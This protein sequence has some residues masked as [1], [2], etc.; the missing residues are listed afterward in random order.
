MEL[1]EHELSSLFP[2]VTAQIRSTLASLHI[3]AAQLA[4]ASDRE[5]DSALDLRAARVDQSY[6][7]LLRLVNT[8]SLAASLSGGQPLPLKNHDLVRLTGQVCEQMD[9]LVTNQGLTLR[10]S[11]PLDQ[12]LCAA[13]KESLEQILFQL[14][15]NAVKF[16]PPGGVITV[17]LRRSFG[18]VLL[19]VEDT[20]PGIPRDQLDTL[21]DRDF[22]QDRPL[23]P[24]HGPGLGLPLC[25][26][27]AKAMGGTL[28]AQSVPGK[29]SRFTLSLPDRQAEPGVSDIPTDYT[30]GFN[31]A[32]LALADA[33]PA[34]AF[35][36]REQD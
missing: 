34:E 10:F 3:A 26:R 22:R 36:L 5:Q 14:L 27:L 2:G 35:R 8:L 12:H 33:L 31:R 24:P 9:T 29:G 20:G 32:L 11:C 6:Y 13:D 30:G 18:Q 7:R 28:V 17:E 25:F 16:T 4:P 23:P 21:F 15:S 1:E 19:S